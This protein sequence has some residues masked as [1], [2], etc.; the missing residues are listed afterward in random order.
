[1][2]IIYVLYYV[3]ENTFCVLVLL[4]WRIKNFLIFLLSGSHYIYKFYF[5]IL[6]VYFI[7]LICG[8]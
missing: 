2:K 6:G 8:I 5:I 4:Y 1:M 3:N 7:A